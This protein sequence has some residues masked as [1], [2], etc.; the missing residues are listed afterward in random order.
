[1]K[2]AT[3]STNLSKERC[4]ALN[5]Q[6][7]VVH[8]L[9]HHGV[10]TPNKETTQLRMVF[11]ASADQKNQQSLNEV[12]YQGPIFLPQIG[13]ILFPFWK[14]QTTIISDAEKTVLQIDYMREAEM[15]HAFCGYET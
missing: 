9:T 15:Q 14:G 2:R 4:I 11:D 13:V 10:T 3:P 8:Y 6:G 5:E 1:M 12:L 7:P